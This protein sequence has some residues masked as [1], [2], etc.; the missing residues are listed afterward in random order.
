MASNIDE[1]TLKMVYTGYIH[2][3]SNY[4]HLFILFFVIQNKCFEGKY[5]YLQIPMVLFGQCCGTGPHTWLRL[6]F[7]VRPN[8]V[9]QGNFTRGGEGGTDT[10]ATLFLAGKGGGHI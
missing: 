7:G 9:V 5:S 10:H 8:F 6:V 3:L 4:N 2:R 1:K